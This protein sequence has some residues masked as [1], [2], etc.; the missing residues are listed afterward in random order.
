MEEYLRRAEYQTS[1]C[2]ES[3]RRS[4]KLIEESKRW[5]SAYHTSSHLALSSRDA[6]VHPVLKGKFPLVPLLSSRGGGPRE[7]A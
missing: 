4:Q 7:P 1:M 2:S 5:L 6:V 3:I